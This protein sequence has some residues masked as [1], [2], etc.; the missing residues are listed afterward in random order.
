MN[1]KDKIILDLC[2]GTGSWS[3]PYVEAGYDVRVITLPSHNILNWNIYPEITEPIEAGKVYGILAAPPCTKFSKAAWNIKKKDRDFAT[4]MT[5]VRACMEVIWRAQEN[6]AHLQFWALE[7]PM[8]YLNRFLGNPPYYFQNWWFGDRSFL[9]TKRTY[10]WGYFNKPKRTNFKRDF[11]FIN[12]HS[13]KRDLVKKEKENKEWYS[14]SQE[15]RAKTSEYFAQ[16]FF[17]VNK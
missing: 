17:D 5:T 9:K 3:R 15:E 10:L 12:P 11:P 6:G 7:N 16:A 14:S 8:G 4:G 2:G 13:S 1:N